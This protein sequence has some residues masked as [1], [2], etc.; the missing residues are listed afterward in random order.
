MS[1]AIKVDID[2]IVTED[3]LRRA[4]SSFGEIEN[5]RLF[6]THYTEP[7]A[8]IIFVSEVAANKVRRLK[9]FRLGSCTV[10]VS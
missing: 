2:G 10:K 1:T 7:F 3:I 8:V 9:E 6:Y 4:F 5:I